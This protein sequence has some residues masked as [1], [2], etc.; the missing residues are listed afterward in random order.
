M[1]F[2]LF[3]KCVK[4]VRPLV[5]EALAG[6]KPLFSYHHRHRIKHHNL[7]APVPLNAGS[8]FELNSLL[9]I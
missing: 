5:A 7:N 3:Q 4:S 8:I 9:R 2:I 1:A 6:G